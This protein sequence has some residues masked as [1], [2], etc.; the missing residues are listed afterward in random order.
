MRAGPAVEPVLPYFDVEHIR[1]FKNIFAF[2]NDKDR[3]ILFLIF[4][5][6]KKQKDVQRILKRSQPSLCY[7]IKRI[8][9]RLKFIF[10]IH[11]VLDEFLVF[12]GSVAEENR[13][14]KAEGMPPVMTEEEMGMLTLML[15]TS[16]FT[17]AAS[18]LG[19]SQVRV[20]YVYNKCL[21][22]I[23]EAERYDMYEVFNIIRRELNIVRRR[24]RGEKGG[25][26]TPLVM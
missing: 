3:D 16:S 9:R 10:Y 1:S 11:S 14:R 4:V 7:D 25:C 5:S 8:R 22:R 12:L 15:Y 18:M 6:R 2:L 19:V 24:F 13:G 21:R 20:R 26:G 23:W 17:M